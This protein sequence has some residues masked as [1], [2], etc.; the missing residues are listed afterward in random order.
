MLFHR[1]NAQIHVIPPD[2]MR[3]SMLFDTKKARIHVL[4][5]KTLKTSLLGCCVGVIFQA[6]NLTKLDCQAR[7]FIC[8]DREL[9]R[10]ISDRLRADSH[11]DPA[12]LAR[13]SRASRTRVARESPRFAHIMTHHHDESIMMMNKS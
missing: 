13:G 9:W 2:T 3:G 12:R 5:P 10:P 1:K 4:L 7:G 11:D 8:T 6:R